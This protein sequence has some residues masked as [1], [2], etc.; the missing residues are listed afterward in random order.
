MKLD[1]QDREG[2]KVKSIDVDDLVFA[3]KTHRSLVHQAM[4]AY[5]ANLHRGTHK[6]KS[7]GEVRGS[8]RKLFRQ[9]GTGRARM[10][11]NRSPIRRGGGVAFGPRPRSYRQDLP[12]RM[13][14]LA[15]RSVLS[16]KVASGKLRVIDALSFDKPQTKELKNV[17][18]ALG[19]ERSTL[20]VTGQSLEALKKSVVG[21]VVD[22]ELA[23]VPQVA[24]LLEVAAHW[25]VPA[26]CRAEAE[27]DGIVAVPVGGLDLSDEA[28]TGFNDCRATH[29]AVF[30]KDLHHA[31]LLAQQSADHSFTSM[32][33]PA[34]SCSRISVS[35][36]RE[37]G[38]SMSM[39][40]LCVRI[41]N[42][43]RE[44]LSMKGERITVNF[45]M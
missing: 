17:L 25:L 22:V 33:T 20:V 27:L 2:K 26:L 45:L 37:D 42:C 29:M 21:R 5:R 24:L 10:G 23:Q 1:V 15:L 19:F 14:R 38:F 13:R 41:S 31:Q 39:M 36:V 35:T 9:K 8:T 7:R 4:L 28:R 6:T 30:I 34:G 40:R 11:S 32:S 18:A 12:K 16:A 3:T 43:S 44:S